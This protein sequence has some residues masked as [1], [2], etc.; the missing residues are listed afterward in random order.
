VLS[1]V[2]SALITG[3]GGSWSFE[4]RDGG[5]LWTQTNSIEVRAIAALLAP[6]VRWNLR[7]ATRRAMRTAKRALE[8]PA[9]SPS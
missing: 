4:A 3:G 6:L 7:R 1:E 9:T 5:T 8:P 2:E